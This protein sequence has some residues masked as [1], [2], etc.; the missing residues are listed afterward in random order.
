MAMGFDFIYQDAPSDLFFQ[1][2]FDK[3]EM[4][5]KNIH[6]R[7]EDLDY[8]KIKDQRSFPFPEFKAL[9]YVYKKNKKGQRELYWRCKMKNSGKIRFFTSKYL[10]YV[11]SKLEK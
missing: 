7:Y 6:A 3:Y 11:R 10:H 5:Y 9:K 8:I 2:K 4:L 1:R